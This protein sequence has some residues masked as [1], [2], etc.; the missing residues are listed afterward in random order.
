MCIRDSKEEVVGALLEHH[1]VLAVGLLAAS[2][3]TAFY[4]ARLFFLVFFGEPRTSG[5]QEAVRESPWVMTLPLV[6]LGLAAVFSGFAGAFLWSGVDGRVIDRA[7]D[8][9][10][11]GVLGLGALVRR[12][13]TGEVRDYLATMAL[14][15]VLIVALALGGA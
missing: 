5:E 2:L 12:A 11:R 6:V 9:L 10:A 15:V 4:I 3:L 13:Q 14:G 1:P 7:V 8:G